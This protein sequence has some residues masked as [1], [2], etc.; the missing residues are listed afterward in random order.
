MHLEKLVE[1]VV[2]TA[3]NMFIR[4]RARNSSR[5]IVAISRYISAGMP[6]FKACHS[7]ICSSALAEIEGLALFKESIISLYRFF[8]MHVDA[9]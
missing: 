8:W 2:G 6:S 7:A 3:R 4:Q 1:D 9:P 5:S